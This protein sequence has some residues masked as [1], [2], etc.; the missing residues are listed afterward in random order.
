MTVPRLPPHSYNNERNSLGYSSARVRYPQIFK[1][2]VEDLRF[3]IDSSANKNKD[4]KRSQGGEII[5]KIQQLAKDLANDCEITAF[6]NDK[7]PGLKSLD[8]SLKEFQN[9]TD[10]PH[11]K[12]MTAPWL[13]SECWLF[14][15]LDVFFKECSEWTNFDVFEKLKR[16]AFATSATGVYELV[17]RYKKLH[18]GK[19]DTI[20]DKEFLK[21]VYEEFVE[22]SLFGN[23]TD[24]ALLVN[25]TPEEL[26]SVQGSAARD[27]ARNNIVTNDLESTWKRIT[28][29]AENGKPKR[30]DF[31]LDN[32][33]FEFF[34]DVC[35]SLF[36][37]DFGLVEEVVYHCKTRP[38]MVSDTMV[39]DVQ[40]MADDLLD[41][42]KF[43]EHRSD[44]EFFVESF[45]KYRKAGKI[46]A[47]DS[48]FW[49]IYLNYANIAPEE[50]K[51]GGADL[52]KY[53]Q[54]STLV[55][56]KGDLNY[57][58][59]TDDRHWPRDTPFTT[60][61]GKLASSGIH[62]VSLR[63]CKSDVCV[64]LPKGK[65]EEL[66]KYWKSLGNEFGET[67]SSSGKWAVISYSNGSA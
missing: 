65:D 62:V 13:F 10:G 59:L 21:I 61:I 1:N 30:V 12:W 19:F 45:N 2:L 64:G 50:T 44:I 56:I 41:A 23:S 5:H 52:W 27:K 67:W 25:A 16:E 54:D 42:S 48:E 8:E 15:K 51:Y 49:T 37:L 38:W 32:A 24:L 35:L 31:V 18:D 17:N 55:I 3:E 29:V 33:G 20:K 36:L 57:R 28:S 47:T 43:P 14:R 9:S 39:K 46:S 22:I 6:S 4:L 60:A 7:I 26:K 34:A 40:L 53:F 58:K 66:C 63:T 11:L